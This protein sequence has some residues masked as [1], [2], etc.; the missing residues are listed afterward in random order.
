MLFTFICI[1]SQATTPN[2]HISKGRLYYLDSTS[3]GINDRL[4]SESRLG[5]KPNSIN[6][7]SPDGFVLI[8]S[9]QKHLPRVLF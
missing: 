1:N 7:D 5:A 6:V 4:S 9:V 2:N 8:E 3:G